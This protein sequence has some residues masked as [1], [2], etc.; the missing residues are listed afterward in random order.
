M[1][2]IK[3][4]ALSRAPL[5]SDTLA[6]YFTLAYDAL[7]LAMDA[8]C[9]SKAYETSSHKSLGELMLYICP[10]FRISVFERARLTRNGIN[11]YGRNISYE[12][13]ITLIKQIMELKKEITSTLQTP[14]RSARGRSLAQSRLPR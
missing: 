6:G 12:E 14:S 5:D 11:Y 2:E 13:G 4:R 7:H 1:A 3:E 8:Y 9:R 10:A